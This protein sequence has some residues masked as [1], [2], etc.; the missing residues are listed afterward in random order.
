MVNGV[1]QGDPYA[2]LD[3]SASGSKEKTQ[4]HLSPGSTSH[5]GTLRVSRDGEGADP[6]TSVTHRKVSP[7]LHLDSTLELT[8]WQ[9]HR[10]ANPE[11]VNMGD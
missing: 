2:G 10:R 4:T 8:C 1:G 3:L 5:M 6:L 9:E 11:N 7:V